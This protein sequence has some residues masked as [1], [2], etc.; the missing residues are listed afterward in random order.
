M[1]LRKPTN[2]NKPAIITKQ[3]T[4]KTYEDLQHENEE[5]LYVV[6]KLS[7]ALSFV[8]AMIANKEKVSA[9]DLWNIYQSMKKNESILGIFGDEKLQSL[10]QKYGNTNNQQ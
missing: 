9:W 8:F 3:E 6:Q 7:T 2:E 5:L 4:T 10:I 1:D